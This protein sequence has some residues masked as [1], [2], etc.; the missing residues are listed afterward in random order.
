MKVNIFTK[1]I[2]DY[3]A[4]NYTKITKP[5]ILKVIH[6]KYGCTDMTAGQLK[7]YYLNNGLKSG[8]D[9][10]GKMAGWNKGLKMSEE[11]YEKCK[12][13]MFKKGQISARHRNVGSERINKAGRI[14]IKVAEPRTW[15]QK[16]RII[17]E[18]HH[19]VKL[20]S[21]DIVTFLDG[22]PLNCDI[23]NLV[24]FDRS[25]LKIINSHFSDVNTDNPEIKRAIISLALNIDAT[26]RAKKRKKENNK[27]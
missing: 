13:T 14:E 18:Q 3:I 26:S 15:K 16:H 11:H 6:E 27:C 19:N 2:E 17:Y 7:R 8:I 23:N 21:N 22:N 5:E 25:I 20:N 1:E 10:K 9:C 24:C 12:G 4:Q